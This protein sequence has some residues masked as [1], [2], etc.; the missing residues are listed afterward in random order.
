MAA[1]AAAPSGSPE[2]KK[3]IPAPVNSKRRSRKASNPDIESPKN[4]KR[5]KKESPL[6]A[7]AENAKRE[8]E[9]NRKDMADLKLMF[10]KFLEVA[11]KL[12]P[13]T[14]VDANSNESKTS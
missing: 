3:Q 7:L 9:D 1:A 12:L 13:Q 10:G 2:E 14:Q 6:S 11:T 8:S 5:T 4:A